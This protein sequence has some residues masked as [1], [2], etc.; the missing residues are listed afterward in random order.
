MLDYSL[1]SVAFTQ[2][3]DSN[4]WGC[5][6]GHSSPAYSAPYMA[7]L[8][9]FMRNNGV[10]TVVDLG[11]GD[12]QHSRAMD[13]SGIRYRGFD[14]VES[15]IAAN[16]KRFSSDT[17]TFHLLRQMAELPDADLVICKDVLQHVPNAD[18]AAHLDLLLHHYKFAIITNDISCTR[19]GCA[20][21]NTNLDIPVG[22][23]RQLQL[24]LPPFNRK[25]ASLLQWP[26]TDPPYRWVKNA[27]LLMV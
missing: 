21:D 25:V 4:A 16:T 20:E 23:Y 7:M 1:A 11:C 27:C 8:A 15:V 14:V 10:R 9:D 6:S 13:W 19:D 18:V 26:I 5:G 2:I 12:W 17:V 3:Y 22:A 24:D